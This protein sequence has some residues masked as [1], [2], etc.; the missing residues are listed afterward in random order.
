MGSMDKGR[1]ASWVGRG[2]IALGAIQTSALLLLL[3]TTAAPTWA[4]KKE[5]PFPVPVVLDLPKFT[6]PL[7]EVQALG[8]LGL[9][10]WNQSETPKVR[11]VNDRLQIIQA[12]SPPDIKLLDALGLAYRQIRKPE[13]A[14]A[15]YKSELA[16]ARS[17][18]LGPLPEFKILNNLGELHLEW[19]GYARARQVYEELLAQADSAQDGVNQVA[20]LYQLAYLHEESRQPVEAAQALR[21]LIPLYQAQAAALPVLLP[22]FQLRLGD[23]YRLVK[24]VEA[25]EKSYQA[26]FN[27]AQS[28]V[29]LSYAQE[30]LHHL[31]ELYEAFDRTPAALQ[32]YDYLSTFEQNDLLDFYNALNSYD[33]LGQLHLKQGDKPRA[34][35]AFG[36]GLAIAQRLNSRVAYFEGKV[37]ALQGKP[38]SIPPKP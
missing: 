31:G 34:L 7:E 13:Q 22:W 9:V 6:N 33:R 5:P 23:N 25:A 37:Q 28:L 14:I 8:A 38:E 17:Q 3:L 11:A 18:N 2:C 10:A 30:N 24:D 15:A 27:S 12:T 4:A 29:Q 16:L 20:Y 36:Q 26:G 21:R 32:V 19:F 1:M 35:V